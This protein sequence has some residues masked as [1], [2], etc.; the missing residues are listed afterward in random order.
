MIKRLPFMKKVETDSK[1]L[2]IIEML[3]K[4]IKNESDFRTTDIKNLTKVLSNFV[5][6]FIERVKYN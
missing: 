5:N 2:I 6:F 1:T 3:E 4:Y